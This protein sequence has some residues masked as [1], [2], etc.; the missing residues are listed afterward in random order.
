[1]SRL[2]N[3]LKGTL[4]SNT[5]QF[6]FGVAVLWFLG[7]LSDASFVTDNPQTTAVL[8]GIVAL[9]NLFLRAKTKKPLKDR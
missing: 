5:V 6:N 2:S 4:K 9:V 3:L 1:M 7:V 8:G